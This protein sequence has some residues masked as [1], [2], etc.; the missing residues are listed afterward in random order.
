MKPFEFQ[1]VL[2]NF[3]DVMLLMTTM[4]CLFF[5]VLL[6]VTNTKNVKTAMFL[7]AFLFAHALIPANELIMWGAEFKVQVRYEWPGLYFILQMAYYLDGPLLFL[8]IKSLVF[9]DFSLRKIDILHIVPLIIY[10]V[11]ISTTFYS[12]TFDERQVMLINESF[13][14]DTGYVSLELFNKGLRVF[15]AIACVIMIRRYR[16]LLQDTYSNIDKAHTNW[17]NGLVYGFMAVMF[18]ETVLVMAKIISLFTPIGNSVFSQIGL[19]GNYLSFVL[20]NLLV[21]T[22]IRHFLT[23]EQVTYKETATKPVD[24]QFVNPEIAT[25]IDIKMKDNKAFMDPDITLDSLASALEITSRDLSMLINRHFG[26]NFYEFINK[27]RIEEAKK[28]LSDPTHKKDTITDI[29]LAVGFNSKSVF[30]TFFKKFEDVTPSQFRKSAL[31]V[32]RA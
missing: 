18:S 31:E 23:F 20:V 29:Y 4:Q 32:G 2:F 12:H 5:G 8:C 6:Y 14:Y 30:Y 16:Y 17:L 21:F 28:M 25:E 26:I 22:A 19:T 1:S 9:K 13:V 24:D 27:Y 10:L 3:H 11:F 15:Y 7:S